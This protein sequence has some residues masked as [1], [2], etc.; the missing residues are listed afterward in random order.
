MHTASSTGASLPGKS[1]VG[2]RTRHDTTSVVT[3][4]VQHPGYQFELPDLTSCQAAWRAAK[5]F[6]LLGYAHSK[7]EDL[8]QAQL[9]D[10]H[11]FKRAFH[12]SLDPDPQPGGRWRSYSAFALRGATAFLLPSNPYMQTRQYNED[13][14]DKPRQF[15]A[16]DSAVVVSRSLKE[17]IRFNLSVAKLTNQSLFHCPGILIGVHMVS[18]RAVGSEVA[19]S[20]PVWLHRDQEEYVSVVLYALSHNVSGGENVLA[21][22][23]RT[24]VE[25]INLTEEFES[26]ILS[27]SRMHAVVPVSSTNGRLA[28]RNIILITFS[29]LLSDD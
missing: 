13:D 29:P 18:Y 25:K 23:P 19:F 15:R 1:R 24:I 2:D 17:L 11:D 21:N 3:G 12:K 28:Y 14:G 22:G 5:D 7:P 4:D 16:L 6:S 10:S 9:D 20:S 27:Q 26:L 8:N